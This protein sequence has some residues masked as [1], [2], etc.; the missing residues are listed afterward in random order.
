MAF[1]LLRPSATSP[2]PVDQVL[3]TLLDT[4]ISVFKA[5]QGTVWIPRLSFDSG[6]IDAAAPLVMAATTFPPE[7]IS[8]PGRPDSSL[9][10][11]AIGAGSSRIGVC[12]RYAACIYYDDLDECAPT[13]GHAWRELSAEE[14]AQLLRPRGCSQDRVLK[15]AG[16]RSTWCIHIPLTISASAS[17][18]SSGQSSEVQDSPG[19]IIVTLD[20]TPGKMHSEFTEPMRDWVSLCGTHIDRSL[21]IESEFVQGLATTTLDQLR[22][23]DR[24]AIDQYV[25]RCAEV[26]GF[27]GC[28]LFGKIPST[29]A[30]EV[31]GTTG[32]LWDGPI[33]RVSLL[34]QGEGPA[35][36]AARQCQL[37]VAEQYGEDLGLPDETWSEHPCPDERVTD[38][39][40]HQAL[41]APIVVTSPH[42][43]A[44]VFG[45]LKLLDRAAAPTTDVS[46]SVVFPLHALDVLRAARFASSTRLLLHVER[47]LDEK[48]TLLS[49]V[50]HDYRAPATQMRIAV[51]RLLNKDDAYFQSHVPDI[52]RTLQRVQDFGGDLIFASDIARL[53]YD[54]E[55]T[56]DVALEPRRIRLRN[57]VVT[58][59]DYFSRTSRSHGMTSYEQLSSDLSSFPADEYVQ[60]DPRYIRAILHQLLDNAMKYSASDQEVE[61]TYVRGQADRPGSTAGCSVVV[62]NYGPGIEGSEAETIF[63]PRRR[64][65]GAVRAGVLGSGMGLARAKGLAERHGLR[66]VL[67]RG[68][69]PT[70]FALVF[71]PSMMVSGA[72]D[73]R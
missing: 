30:F 16:L 14:L 39:D 46:P 26:L 43:Q 29:D 15:S 4:L 8:V 54:P 41:A 52:R 56:K 44:E 65:R 62:S 22:G 68:S 11:Q 49:S 69:I 66:L 13:L 25:S 2:Q 38:K 72:V 60:A 37:V 33:G 12:F 42:A 32:M 57:V 67:V 24:T 58:L 48:E 35:A 70:S 3:K 73:E 21:W 28:T 63:L 50:R 53:G 18:R 31:V 27:E 71:P 59:V 17:E 51:A 7:H 64:G 23:G 1:H 9:I 45:V 47:M 55:A 40:R 10:H 61:I 5:D 19:A 6:R 20:G 34:P 36:T